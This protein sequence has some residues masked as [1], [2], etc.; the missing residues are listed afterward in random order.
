MGEKDG[1]L[2][3]ANNFDLFVMLW[4][5]L[6]CFF[7]IIFATSSSIIFLMGDNLNFLPLPLGLLELNF[8]KVFFGSSLYL[9]MCCPIH[10]CIWTLL[11]WIFQP[12]SHNLTFFS[13]LHLCS[14]RLYQYLKCWPPWH[15]SGMANLFNW[16]GYFWYFNLEK[17]NMVINLLTTIL[18]SLL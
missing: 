7:L 4:L 8:K 2:F 6:L 3:V 13:L 11:L 14:I 18:R 16:L 1:P 5:Q 12:E 15:T 9:N 17:I 10:L